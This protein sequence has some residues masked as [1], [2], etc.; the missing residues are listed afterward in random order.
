M[1]R[2]KRRRKSWRSQRENTNK[3]QR[4]IAVLAPMHR[5][6]DDIHPGKVMAAAEWLPVIE[7]EGGKHVQKQQRARSV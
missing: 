3:Q 5:S 2:S 7:I 6:K 4:Y 1:P